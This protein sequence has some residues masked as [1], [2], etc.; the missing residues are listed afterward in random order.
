MPE[1]VPSAPPRPTAPEPGASPEARHG[2]GMLRRF[3]ALYWLTGLGLLGLRAR[4]EEHSAENVRAAAEQGP[5]VY[6]MHTRSLLDWLA[7][8]RVLNQRRLPLPRYSTG[9]RTFWLQPLLEALRSAWARLRARLRD[10]PLPDAIE[11]GWLAR[12][13]AA[14]MP[15][16]VF[17]TAA[18]SPWR[19]RVRAGEEAVHALLQAQS[20]GAR[21]VQLVPVVVVWHRGAGQNRTEAERFVLGSSDEP[22]PLLKL[23]TVLSG[24][25]SAVVQAGRALDLKQLLERFPE[26]PPRRQARAA[27]IALRR[28]LYRE[29]HTIRGPQIRPY[30]WT[31]RLVLQSPEVRHLVRAEAARTGRPPAAVERKVEATLDAIAAR[32]SFPFVRFADHFCRFLFTRIYEGVDMRPEDAERLRQAVRAGTPIVV[33]CHRSHLDYILI[34]W[35][36]YQHDLAIPHVCAGDNLAFWPLGPVLRRVGGFFIKRSFKGETVFPVVFE[37]Y[38]RQLIR[39]GFPIEFYPEGARSR[40]GK[41]LPARHG[42]LGMVLDAAAGGRS[43]QEV[44][45]VPMAICYE[46]IAEEGSYARE[47]AGEAK[48]K[49]DVGQVVRAGRVFGK[50]FGRVF[51]RVGEPLPARAVF[52]EAGAPWREL[53]EDQR[54]RALQRTGAQIM[55]RVADSLVVLPTGLVAAGLLAQSRSGLRR[56]ALQARCQRLLAFLQRRGALMADPDLGGSRAFDGALQRFTREG[57]VKILAGDDGEPLVEVV[58]DKRITLEYYKNGLLHAFAPASLLA[59]LVRAEL[60]RGLPLDR[61][62]L[63]VG[64]LELIRSLRLEFVFDPDLDDGALCAGAEADLLAAGALSAGP[65]GALAAGQ[66]EALVELAELT[67]NFVESYH[68]VLAVAEGPGPRSPARELPR[69]AQAAAQPRVGADDHLRRPEALSIVNL[70][71]A[72]RVW[73]EEGLIDGATGELR[74]PERAAAVRERLHRLLL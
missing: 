27:H 54:R 49:E 72:A 23:W 19:P 66:R 6:V 39:D 59:L 67:R 20:D 13:V 10:G 7:V 5:V 52:A 69:R 31:R 65:D 63:H 29:Q 55:S 24:G 71:N 61:A 1:P 41:L 17:L 9:V 30:R 74:Q 44:T 40:T 38:L 35:V 28:N 4:L 26:D 43:D 25:G 70:Q 42:V 37:R 32:M 53:S 73:V 36:F 18:R 3:G 51:L 58:P 50:R 46:Q 68:L 21:P 56:A 64:L 15:A 2:S 8:N 14:G 47:L 48:R 60:A 45:F 12:A 34:S 62:A 16:L 57:Y 22:G 11:S 33:P